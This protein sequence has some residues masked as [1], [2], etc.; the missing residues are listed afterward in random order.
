[1]QIRL[2]E[3]GSE[4]VEVADN[5]GG[6]SPANYQALTLKYHTSKIAGF[7][8]LQ[9]GGRQLVLSDVEKELKPPY[10]VAAGDP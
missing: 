10:Q 8:D 9:V 1:M 6:V 2:K 3:C 7:G 4:L 5:G